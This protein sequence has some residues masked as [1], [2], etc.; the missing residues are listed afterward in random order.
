MI[1]VTDLRSG[2][3]FQLWRQD[4]IY[5]VQELGL[6]LVDARGYWADSAI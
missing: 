4:A 1:T 5:A 6:P 2:E 3:T